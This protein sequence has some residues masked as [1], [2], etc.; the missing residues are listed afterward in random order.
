MSGSGKGNL[1]ESKAVTGLT[2]S[3]TYHFRVVA[4]NSRGTTYGSDRSFSTTGKPS[5]ETDTA[6]SVGDTEADLNGLVNPRGVETKYDFEYGPTISYGSKT[7]EVSAGS[8]TS[9]LGRCD[10]RR[11]DGERQISL[12]IARRTVTGRSMGGIR[13]FRRRISRPWKPG[14]RRASVKPKGR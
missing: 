10:H 3:T 6:T 2:A 5:V 11:L 13:C 9:N 4:T 12:R 14:P 7:A 8:G 1:E